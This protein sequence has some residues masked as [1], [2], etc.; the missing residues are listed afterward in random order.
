MYNVKSGDELAIDHGMTLSFARERFGVTWL[1]EHALHDVQANMHEKVYEDQRRLAMVHHLET[2]VLTMDEDE[3]VITYPRDW[4]E[5][6]KSRFAPLWFI[7]R[8]PVKLEFVKEKRY[9]KVFLSVFPDRTTEYRGIHQRYQC[10]G[11]TLIP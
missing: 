1:V 6:V 5:A 3:I 7:K 10:F 2:S 9:G 4:W 11:N 8:W